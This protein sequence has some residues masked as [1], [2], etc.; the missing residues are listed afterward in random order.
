MFL[1]G[2]LNI[3][4]TKI[5][6]I[7]AT[8]VIS[9]LAAAANAA[10]IDSIGDLPG[11][12]ISSA[13]AGISNDGTVIVGSSI[14]N[15]GVQAF[16]WTL[17]T[18]MIN[19]DDIAGTTNNSITYA[20][21]NDGSVVV[22]LATTAGG[23]E[24]FRWT[25][26]TGM[27]GLGYLPGSN[28]SFAYSTNND[29]SIVVGESI[30]GSVSEAFRWTSGTGMIGL[31]FLPGGS[32]YSSARGISGDGSII[33]GSSEGSGIYHAFRWTSGTGMVD[34]G[35]LA[36]GGFN[37]DA[38]NIST[39]GLVIVG[40]SDTPAGTE[41]FRWTAGTG[42]VG[43]GDLA[44]GNVNSNA[45]AANGNG[46]V[47]VGIGETAAG[48]EAFRWTSANGIESL[49]DILTAAGVNLTGW[50][51]SAATCIDDSGN[52]ITGYGTYLGDTMAFLVNTATAA[53]TTVTDFSASLSS[54]IIPV[55]QAQSA[56]VNN[57]DQSLFAA[58]Q[59]FAAFDTSIILSDPS[60]IAPAAGD[61]M[62]ARS[63]L[64]DKKWSGYMVGSFNIGQD[65]DFDN[66]NINGTMGI[67]FSPNPNM[68]FGGGLIGSH[69]R[70]DM[71]HSGDSQ[72][73]SKGGS[74][75]FAYKTDAGFRLYSTA[76]AAGISVET[77]RNYIN[78][79]GIDTSYGDTDGMGYG[80]ALR[81]GWEFPIN[82]TTR[83]MPY[84]EIH[85]SRT[86][87]DGYTETSGGF[88]ATFGKT[89]NDQMT[90]RLGAEVSYDILPT[91]SFS[92]RAAWAHRIKESDNG[93]SVSTTGFTGVLTPE[94]GDRNWAEGTISTRW[95][96]S[97]K[98]TFNAELTGRTGKTQDPA[99]SLIVGAKMDF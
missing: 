76:F 66:N 94:D 83:I 61:D 12:A 45:L 90:S 38:F 79:T 21:N 73:D 11:G 68:I 6:L 89:T 29:G 54:A 37:S 14:S 20:A 27:I 91:L 69:G 85:L 23:T 5:I 48:A 16:R 26:G 46:S 40:G 71:S 32:I 53:V 9:L 7:A 52:L 78:G 88:P 44:G 19:I 8:T 72:L 60:A 36:G 70:S 95:Q 67:L 22:G 75:L 43:L 42:M 51:L 34:L 39:D 84:G 80:F 1:T 96:A 35:D 33:V 81:S 13:G 18:G 57:I 99:V 59:S 63:F 30:T 4:K 65:N 82:H 17:G 58:T 93:L 74:M 3:M 10:S 92:G 28:F 49:S 56:I 25:S 24:A 50:S 41:A 55:Q 31:G 64:S 2:K 98:T 15:N 87:L 47:I 62:D 86:T 97:S 77:T